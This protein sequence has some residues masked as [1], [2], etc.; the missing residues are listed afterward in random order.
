MPAFQDFWT[1]THLQL[2]QMFPMFDLTAEGLEAGMKRLMAK[3]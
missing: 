3:R 1:V 2:A